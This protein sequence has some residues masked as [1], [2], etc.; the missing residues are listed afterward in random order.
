MTLACARCHDHKFDPIPTSDYY[1]MAGILQS[2][3]RQRAMLDPRGQIQ[4]CAAQLA[5]LHHA[6][7]TLS[8]T[9]VTWQAQLD[10]RLNGGLDDPTIKNASH[11]AFILRELISCDADAVEQRSRELRNDVQRQ[12]AASQTSRANATTLVDFSAQGFDDWFVTGEAF[13]TTPVRSVRLSSTSAEPRFAPTGVAASNQAGNKL[14]GVLRSPTFEIQ[15][16]QI[17]YR[18]NCD[19]TQIRLIVD[20]Y[21]MDTFSSLLFADCT[22]NNVKTDGEFRWITQRRDLDHYQGHRAHI[23]ILDEGD[24]FAVVAEIVFS[25]QGPPVDPPTDLASRWAQEARPEWDRAQ[26]LAWWTDHWQEVVAANAAE[27]NREQQ[28]LLNWLLQW[29]VV[30]VAA[31]T[32]DRYAAIKAL[33]AETPTPIYALAI[34]EGTPEDERIHIRGKHRNLG[35]TVPR[36]MLVA[37]CAHERDA[38]ATESGRGML[39]EELTSPDNPLV[40]RVI[41]N[42]LWHHLF[43]RGIVSSVDDFGVMGTAPTHPELL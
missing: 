33:E 30:S 22:L 3:R 35:A 39:A 23:E 27:L 1:S 38:P 9:S 11:P 31:E 6:A 8:S 14:R 19:A 18:I 13:G 28:Q 40:A 37:A 16:Q 34:A 21:V 4:Q 24:G 25:D 12:Q 15:H 32:N 26:H 42:R 29:K 5:V 20:G 41:V 7:P 17:H 2:S 43:G 36:H 10:N